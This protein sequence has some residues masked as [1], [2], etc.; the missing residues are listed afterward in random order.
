MAHK[1]LTHKVHSKQQCQ[2]EYHNVIIAQY[3]KYGMHKYQDTQK[4]YYQ[5]WTEQ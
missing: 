4:V 1:H 3:H 2:H 5:I